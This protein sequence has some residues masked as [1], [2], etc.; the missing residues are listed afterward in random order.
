MTGMDAFLKSLPFLV[1]IM[2]QLLPKNLRTPF[3][4]LNQRAFL[5][6]IIF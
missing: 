4:N 2:S 1:I 3:Y 6:S 5:L